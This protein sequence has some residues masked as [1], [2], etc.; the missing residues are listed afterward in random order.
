VRANAWHDAI[1]TQLRA[2]E[3]AAL[4]VSQIWQG[5]AAAGFRHGS[6]QPVRTL[7]ARIAELAQAKKLERMGPALYRL[8][9]EAS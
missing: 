4:T 5:M 3:G 2:A 6:E 1:L 8:V 9:E 7:A